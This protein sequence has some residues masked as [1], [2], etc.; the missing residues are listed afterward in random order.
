MKK[1]QKRLRLNRET[2]R[3]LTAEDL[4]FVGGGGTGEDE[5]TICGGC[6]DL[7]E[8]TDESEGD[9]C[10][11]GGGTGGGTIG[12]GGTGGGGGTLTST[13]DTQVYVNTL[14]NMC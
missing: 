5:G 10:R 8:K 4:A 3:E 7:Q 14:C 13:D 9:V 11:D 2:I 12:G 6:V 1:L